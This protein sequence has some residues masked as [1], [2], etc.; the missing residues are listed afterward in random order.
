MDRRKIKNMLFLLGCVCSTILTIFFLLGFLGSLLFNSY[1][2]L[3]IYKI[4]L[5]ISLNPEIYSIKNPQNRID[6]Y[7][8]LIT[9][10]FKKLDLEVEQQSVNHLINYNSLL[11]L[12]K[13]LKKNYSKNSSYWSIVSS[14]AENYLKEE[15]DNKIFIDRKTT[16]LI[17][18]LVQL[19]FIKKTFNWDFIINK[20]SSDV[21]IAGIKTSFYGSII[22]AL[23]CLLI[24][25][26]IGV[27]TSI[28]LKFFS[29]KNYIY[30]LI[31]LGIVNL[32]AIPSIIYGVIGLFIF[33]NIFHIPRSSILA[34]TLTLA[35]LAIPM[36]IIIANHALKTLDYELIRAA[37]AMGAS[38]IQVIFFHVIPMIFP[39]IV[40]GS[41][42][43][44]ARIIGETAPLI[45]IGMVAYITTAPSNLI[46]PATTLPI[47]IY[48]WYGHPNADFTQ[49]ASL[50]VL[51]LLAILT[52][53]NIVAGYIK[54]YFS[55]Q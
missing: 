18:S 15:K 49:K 21:Q 16:K 31:E 11:D 7:K 40:T 51:I 32:A 35:L 25:L 53:F 47:Q 34:G 27:I 37:Y 2:S 17:K 45:L 1:K 46:S 23:L 52:I 5:S 29:K 26:P 41:I 10:S 33:I 22:I 12:D 38:K 30:K 43:A 55:K 13:K 54:N 36:I 24:S 28:Y 48:M 42:L 9:K 39:S 19:G 6:I 50:A 20:D 3:T 14:E 8:K 4:K 44:T